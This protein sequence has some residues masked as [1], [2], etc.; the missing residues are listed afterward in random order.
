MGW[1]RFMYRIAPTLFF[2][3]NSCTFATFI[4]KKPSR[5]DWLVYPVNLA[6]LFWF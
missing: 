4:Y 5:A 6:N 2:L 3:L 1:S